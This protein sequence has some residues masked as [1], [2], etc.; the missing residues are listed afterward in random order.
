MSV[1]SPP[2]FPR[3]Y[4]QY[5]LPLH[6]EK[7]NLGQ[8]D[9][10]RV[11]SVRHPLYWDDDSRMLEFYATDGKDGGLHHETVRL[12]CAVVA[13]NA[14]DGFLTLD[15]EGLKRIT[16]GP[17]EILKGSNY[18]FH[19][20]PPCEDSMSRCPCSIIY[21]NWWDVNSETL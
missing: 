6:P 20:A 8:Y 2:E 21:A 5:T 4:S 12:A 9:E 1:A 19:A 18:F 15:R 10:T 14:F 3:V 11:V 17:D 13:C 16:E 7:R